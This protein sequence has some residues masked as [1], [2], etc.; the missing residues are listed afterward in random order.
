MNIC[1]YEPDELKD[2]KLIPDS[3]INPKCFCNGNELESFQN[4]GAYGTGICTGDDGRTVVERMEL[5]I[6]IYCYSFR[7]LGRVPA[8]N[9]QDRSFL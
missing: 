3:S 9:K 2:S 1:K 6:I 5:S 7:L 8:V 4:K